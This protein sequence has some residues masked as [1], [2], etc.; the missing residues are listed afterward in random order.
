[1]VKLPQ[2]AKSLHETT[3]LAPI[4]R[5][6]GALLEV[7]EKYVFSWRGGVFFYKP[8][9]TGIGLLL[10]LSVLNAT[11]RGND[12]AVNAGL[13]IRLLANPLHT[14]DIPLRTSEGSN[15]LPV[16]G[17]VPH[18]VDQ[19]VEADL[20][21]IDGGL[22]TPQFSSGR[23]RSWSSPAM[24][25]NA[26]SLRSDAWL[27]LDTGLSYPLLD[28]QNRQ[29]DKELLILE[30]RANTPTND[31]SLTLG[32][33]GRFSL[34][35]ASTNE[36]SKFPY[37]GRFPTDFSGDSATDARLLQ[38]NAH[39][40]AAVNSWATV[41]W[42]LLFSDVFTFDSFE[43]GSLQTRQAY[44]VFGDLQ[45]SPLYLYVGKKNVGF[46]DLETLS[47]FTQSVVWHYFAVLAEGIGVG[48]HGDHWDMTLAGINGGRGIRVADSVERGKLNNFAG[49]IAYRVGV[50][51]CHQLR[52]GGGFLYGTIYDGETAEH[53]DTNQ[54]G[55]FYNSAWDVNARLDWGRWSASGE[56]VST[57]E[58]WPV[59]DERV[60]AYRAE[61][62]YRPYTARPS[63]LSVSWSEGR[64]GEG[65]S[66]FEFNRQLVLGLGVR[67]HRRAFVTTEYVRSSGFA[68]LINITTVS[69]RSVVQ[70][71]FVLGINLF[72]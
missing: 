32:A 60:S 61:A 52:L 3:G 55:T 48:Y 25:P 51:R 57:L 43:Q 69:D 46:G 4:T 17:S 31:F 58:P 62:A 56:F 26:H 34:L 15:A 44:A 22:G 66:E 12:V 7:F 11:V 70:N 28:F 64:Q 72:F 45:Q 41:Y 29:T 9:F 37:L 1:M 18:S 67:V 63:Q 6:P 65:G 47:P 59:T 19:N 68:P 14:Q 20:H 42:E 10:Y 33:Q 35:A 54:F 16:L 21:S 71:S 8:W 40:T 23:H 24:S 53:L 27:R 5:L 2:N 49:N 38:A 36:T 50:D 39:I 13:P 30:S